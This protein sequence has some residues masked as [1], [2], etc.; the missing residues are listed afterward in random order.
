MISSVLERNN[1]F[2]KV[3]PRRMDSASQRGSSGSQHLFN[4]RSNKNKENSLRQREKTKEA[5]TQ[6]AKRI[7]IISKKFSMI[8]KLLNVLANDSLEKEGFI[9]PREDLI[10]PAKKVILDIFSFAYIL[11]FNVNLLPEGGII[12]EF[13]IKEKNRRISIELNNDGNHSIV[14]LKDKEIF[15][16]SKDLHEHEIYKFIDLELKKFLI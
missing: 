4:Y 13:K 2:F 6:L 3:E 9:K 16:I 5:L 1:R 12:I 7:S 11:P 10:V 8:S 15:E 14:V